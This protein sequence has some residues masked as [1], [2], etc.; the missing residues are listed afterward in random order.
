[1]LLWIIGIH[2]LEAY[3]LNPKIMGSAARIHPIVVVLALL[4]GERTYGLIG[5]LLAV[6]VAAMAVA[7]FDFVRQRAQ[8]TGAASA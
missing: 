4:A 5:A 2:L 3:F 7:C 1:M 6:P 8:R